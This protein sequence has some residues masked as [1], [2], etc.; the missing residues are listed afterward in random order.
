MKVLITGGAGFIASH[1][2]DLYIESGLDVVIVDNLSTGNAD[3]LN[4]KAKFYCADIRS[5]EFAKI[6]EIEKPNVVNHH[7]AQISVPLSVKDPVRDVDVN[8][9]GTVNVLNACVNNG[10]EKVIF[11]SSGGAIYGEAEEYPPTENC[12]L[13]PISPYAIDKMFGESYVKYFHDTY[14]LSYV[15][16]RYA[17]VYGPRQVPHGEAGAVSIFI[18]N[19]LSGKPV[20]IYGNLDGSGGAIRDY[21]YVKDVANANL[22]ALQYDKCDIFNIGTGIGTNTLQLYCEITQ[23]MGLNYIPDSALSR[24]GDAK[25]SLLNCEKAY[26]LLGWRNQCPLPFGIDET[27]QYFIDRSI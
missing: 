9:R 18:E 11:I 19:L 1:V 17:N 13:N 26:K 7:A 15:I 22:Q 20:V 14:G 27:I 23:Q 6:V 16:L 25:R 2:S 8:V 5:E 12:P 24:P 3:N 10:V 4:P 21:V